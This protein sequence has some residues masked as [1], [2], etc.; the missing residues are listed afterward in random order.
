[1]RKKGMPARMRGTL[2]WLGIAGSMLAGG[3]HATDYIPVAVVPS[4]DV[5]AYIQQN[6]FVGAFFGQQVTG[7]YKSLTVFGDS[8]AD[9]GN[10]LRAG[11]VVPPTGRYSNGLSMGDA[12]QFHYGLPTSSVSNYAVGGA[13]S[14]TTNIASFFNPAS[15]PVLPGTQA[16]IQTFIANGGHFGKADLVDITTAGG[17]DSVPILFGGFTPA[18]ITGL[19]QQVTSNVV[20]DVQSL[21][22]VG[23]RNITI[24]SP[25]DIS[26]LPIGAGNTAIHSYDLQVF[27]IEQAALAPL[28][29]SG[30]RIFFFD[31]GTLAQRVAANPTLYGFTAAT[32]ATPCIAVPSCVAGTPAVQNTY[33]TYD[34]LHLSTAGFAIVGKYQTNQIDAPAT[35]GAQGE[36]GQMATEA[37]SGSLFGRLDAYREQNAFGGYKDGG[38][39]G[40]TRSI[41]KATLRRASGPISSSPSGTITTC[42]A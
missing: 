9:W 40:P 3:A 5:Y 30:V 31:L 16:E 13:K 20:N 33:L 18:A 42:R 25:G 26:Y 41:S 7:Q 4:P 6:P 29:H 19:A 17:N 1:M 37:F 28:A 12:L 10:A 22:N 23:A 34:G 38:P 15:Q 14:D 27:Q 8:Y 35:I 36:L 24:L 39:A 2:G 21:V 32:V 11:S